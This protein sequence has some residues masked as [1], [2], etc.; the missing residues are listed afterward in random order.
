MRAGCMMD[1]EKEIETLKEKIAFYERVLYETSTPIIP[2]IIADTILIPITGYM[3]QKRFDSIRS[4]V[5]KYVGEH[6]EMNCAVF[7]LTGV[8]TKD[9]AELDF[10]DLTTE[11]NLLNTSLKLMGIRPIFVGFNT[12]LIREIVNAG[13]HVDIETYVN[14]KTAMTSVLNEN[15]KLLR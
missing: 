11:I 4:R 12:R 14:F 10:H 1:Y 7:D 5:L 2:S 6:R 8:E 15:E 3:D 9:V 13:I